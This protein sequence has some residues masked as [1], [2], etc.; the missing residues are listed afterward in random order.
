MEMFASRAKGTFADVLAHL[1]ERLTIERLAG[2]AAMSPRNF[3]RV[4]TAETGTTPEGD[5]AP[6]PGDRP[7]RGRD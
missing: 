3:A 7:D 4:F 2:R 5:G 6:A 1:A